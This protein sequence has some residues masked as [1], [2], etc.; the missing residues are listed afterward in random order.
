[1]LLKQNAVAPGKTPVLS[2]FVLALRQR[3]GLL[4]PLG[5]LP[6]EKGGPEVPSPSLG[7]GERTFLLMASSM[8]RTPQEALRHPVSQSYPPCFLSARNKTQRG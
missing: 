2:S 4:D 1:M 5:V 7:A 8:R 6:R 3:T